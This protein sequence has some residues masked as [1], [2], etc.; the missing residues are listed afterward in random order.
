MRSRK[1]FTLIEL[2]VVIAIIAVLIGLLL[3]AIQKVRDAADRTKCSNA[4]RQVGIAYNNWATVNSGQMFTVSGWNTPTG[5]TSL[6][7]N[8]EGNTKML[9]C[10]STLGQPATVLSALSTVTWA[11]AYSS[12]TYPGPPGTVAPSGTSCL[13]GG[14]FFN[15]ANTYIDS[16]LTWSDVSWGHMWLT[17][18]ASYPN[19]LPCTLAMDLGTTY[20]NP[21]V[22]IWNY[23]ESGTAY[24]YDGAKDFTL[25][26]GDGTTWSTPVPQV[27][28][29]ATGPAT[30]PNSVNNSQT[31]PVSGTGRYIKITVTSAHSEVSAPHQYGG[32]LGAVWVL[33]TTNSQTD[34]GINAY[35][36][37]V[38]KFNHYANTILALDYGNTSAGAITNT[39]NAIGA[40]WT[41]YAPVNPPGTANSIRHTVNRMNVVYL[42]GHVESPDFTVADSSA[43]NPNTASI[44]TVKWLDQ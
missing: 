2:L 20:T 34:Y 33:P 6:L 31:F 3:P 30:A 18:C 13:Q 26:I 40:D 22:R 12:G 41:S 29:I 19:N 32:S 15:P 27:L 25:S 9:K 42:D 8:L 36:G 24:R 39:A 5:V 11:T 44:A 16:T 37:S 10:P 23:N 43:V 17:W 4:L 21:Q 1:G 35:V 38:T 7:P 28:N 14:F